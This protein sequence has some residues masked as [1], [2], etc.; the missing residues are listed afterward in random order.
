MF[1]NPL[2]TNVKYTIDG[3]PNKRYSNGLKAWNQFD[4]ISKHFMP[5][6]SKPNHTS[7]IDLRLYYCENKFGLWTDLRSTEDNNLHGTGK[8]HN[9]KNVI[10]MEI[11]KKSQGAGKYTMYVYAVSD[12]RIKIKNK[13]L[14]SFEY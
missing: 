10:K 7:A 6:N 5:E 3:L 1:K 14:T 13:M 2:I 9:A 8:A 11:T 4:E 12:A